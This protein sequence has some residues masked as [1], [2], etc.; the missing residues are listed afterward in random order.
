MI[1]VRPEAPAQMAIALVLSEK[2]SEIAQI[3]QR[4]RQPRKKGVLHTNHF[5][6]AKISE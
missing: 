5:L 6:T 4:I 2:K 1:T 3:H